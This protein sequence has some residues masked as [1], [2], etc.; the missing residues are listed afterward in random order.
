[1]LSIGRL[2]SATWA[3]EYYLSRQ[4]GCP[5]DYYTGAGERPGRW[6][7]S[8]AAALGLRGDVDADTLRALLAGR[9]PDGATRLLRPVLR[10]DP[11]GR[12]PV[13]PLADRLR[14]LAAERDCRPDQL[15]GDE[16]LRTACARLLAQEE[17]ASRQAGAPEPTVNAR[18]AGSLCA[19][20]GIDPHELYRGSDGDGADADRFAAALEQADERIDVRMPGL[21]LTFSAPKSV[22][23][24]YG[25]ATPEVS[26]AVRDGHEAAVRAAVGYLERAAGHG[27]RGHQG[28]RRQ[29]R[30]VGTS[31]FIAATFPH[32]SNRCGDMQLHDHVVVVNLLLGTDGRVSALDSREIYRQGRTA[33]FLYQAALRYELTSRLGVEWG[34]VRNGYAELVGIPE[35]VRRQFSKRRQ[36]I[37]LALEEAGRNDPRAAQAATLATRPLKAAA[38]DPTSLRDRWRV[39]ALA[40]GFDPAGLAA[41]TGATRPAPFTAER[42][43]DLIARLLSGHGLT[44]DDSAFDRLAV[45]RAVAER[46]PYGA[47]VDRIE[48]CADELLSH[49][50]TVPVLTAAGPDRRRYSTVEL[51]AVEHRGLS[52]ATVRR[53]AGVG[54]VDPAAVDDV[55]AAHPRLTGEQQQMV[56]RLLRSGAGVDPVVGLA[57]AGKTAAL[58]A[59]RQGWAAAGI[60]VFGTAVAASAARELQQ[61]SGIPAQSITRLLLDAETVDP[62]TRRPAGLAR[63]GVLVVDEAGMVGTRAFTRL[64]ELAAE[65]DAKLVCVGDPRQLPAIAAGGMFAALVERLEG[66]DL[67][68]NLRQAQAWER[69][70]LDEIRAGELPRAVDRYAD[71]DRLHTAGSAVELRHRLVDHWQAIRA[72]VSDPGAVLMLASR[73][74]DVRA[75]NTLARDRLHAA[76][77]LGPVAVSVSDPALGDRT[78]A[79]GDRIV[80]RRNSYQRGLLNGSRGQV[81]AVDPA[82]MTVTVRAD[83]G[84]VHTLDGAFLADRVDHGYAVT[85]HRAQGVTVDVALV[86][87]DMSLGREGG[88]VALSRGRRENHLYLAADDLEQLRRGGDPR[89][90]TDDQPRTRPERSGSVE[91]RVVELLSR[92]RSKELATGGNDV[93]AVAGREDPLRTWIAER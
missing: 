50:D 39:E 57:G 88:Y 1:M 74:D 4:A 65:A 29:A 45:L 33:G 37:V 51:L 34:P 23:V 3:A 35:P 5:T 47:P 70:A 22:S 25:L 55:L 83:D 53:T 36:Q 84:Q 20:A 40:T 6:W 69:V 41:I 18:T 80:V 93:A 66:A 2:A 62:A 59:A 72:G 11:R 54:V 16:R 48:A 90:E 32:R 24:L 81:L 49:P 14:R 89:G 86:L 63:G 27:L 26:R 43:R 52:L 71:H 78:F 42:Q 91:I 68:T 38:A 61:A 19:A 13:A 58:R 17:R 60:P 77:L 28:D 7:G 10:T 12:L 67:A 56:R 46:L 73:R 79:V 44:R 9:S 8:G 31:G 75:L 76:G 82:E 92:S 21:D 64:L 87:A 15:Y 30:R 85:V